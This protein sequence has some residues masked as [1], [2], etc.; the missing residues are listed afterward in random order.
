MILH[1]H[2][3]LFFGE[4]SNFLIFLKVIYFVLKLPWYFEPTWCKKMNE[5]NNSRKNMKMKL[6]VINNL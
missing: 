5:I 4:K 1:V 3:Q 2:S 6:I